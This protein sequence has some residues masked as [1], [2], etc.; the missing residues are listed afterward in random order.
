MLRGKSLVA[1]LLFCLGSFAQNVVVVTDCNLNGWVKQVAQAGAS[2]N[3]V[4]APPAPILGKG[5]LEFFTPQSF[6]RFRNTLYHHTLLSS[7]TELSYST[8]IQSHGSN[9][10]APYIILQVDRN[11]DDITDDA[12]AFNP[13]FQTGRFIVSGSLPDQGPALADTW[14]T[15]DALHGGW[16]LG[17]APDPLNNGP[18]FSLS[19]YINQNPT[20]RI[21][22][23]GAMGTGGI[24]LTVGGPGEPFGP[25]LKGNADNF[26][27]GVNGQTTVYDFEQT[28]AG[29]GP[30]RQV[31]FGYGSNCIQLSGTAAGGVGPYSFSWSPGG[32]SPSAPTTQVCPEL[33]TTYVLTVTDANGCARTDDVTV[34]VTDVRCGPKMDKVKLCHKG[35]DLCVASESVSAHLNHGDKLGG[36]ALTSSTNIR[37][38]PA[39][40]KEPISLSNYPNPFSTG[41]T[42]KYTLPFDAKVSL[43]VYDF[44][45]RTVATITEAKKGPG[46]HSIL[47]KPGNLAEGSY[48]YQLTLVTAT[49]QFLQTG[50]MMIIH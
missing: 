15:W 13:E 5:S 7:I 46:E 27:I 8:Y 20:A 34:Y 16:W 23:A 30:D 49:K 10:F 18:V 25:N 48:Y 33:T 22:N 35:S 21:V 41:T 44:T 39:E 43:K 32:T 28:T 45:G 24:R 17:P 6:V 38:H 2:A 1:G 47:F 37:S 11:G 36:C 42:I 12:L 50:R 14:Q 9:V 26:R 29:A 3:F 40:M 31:I 4:N 19:S